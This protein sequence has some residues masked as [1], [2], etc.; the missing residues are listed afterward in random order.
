[1]LLHRLLLLWVKTVVMTV[2]M[3]TNEDHDNKDHQQDETTADAVDEG[4]TRAAAL[5]IFRFFE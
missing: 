4:W 2:V 3:M 5:L 1:V